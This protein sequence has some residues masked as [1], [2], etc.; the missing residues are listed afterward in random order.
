MDRTVQ[1]L[2]EQ[3]AAAEES[4]DAD[5]VAALLTDDFT[6]VGPA[7]FVLTRAQW[8]E[9]FTSGDLKFEK[10]AW[11]DV[12]FRIH[13]DTAVGI[14]IQDQQGTFQD[15]RVDGRFRGTQIYTRQDG[16]WKILGMQLS[17]VRGPA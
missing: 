1:E 7:G 10:L 13:G 12:Q 5:A 8:L 11:E 4:G 14:G 16:V 3:W 6:A 9:R 15:R 2:S 17:P